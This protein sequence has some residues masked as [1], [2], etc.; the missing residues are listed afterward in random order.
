MLSVAVVPFLH[1]GIALRCVLPVLWMA[2]CFDT[3]GSIACHNHAYNSTTVPPRKVTYRDTNRK[4]LLATQTQ[5]LMWAAAMT[6]S[7]RN[8]VLVPFDFGRPQ[9]N[10]DDQVVYSSTCISCAPGTKSALYND[11]SKLRRP[12][13]MMTIL[14]WMWLCT[15]SFS[16]INLKF[17]YTELDPVCTM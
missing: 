15:R 6:G 2:S 9:L 11:F 3:I 16:S 14:A 1:G 4:S 7:A 17:V 13:I 5:P 10:G 8:R 12:W